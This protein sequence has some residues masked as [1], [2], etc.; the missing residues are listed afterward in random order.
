MRNQFKRQP[1][2]RNHFTLW[3]HYGKE[4]KRKVIIQVFVLVKTLILLHEKLKSSLTPKVRTPS[5]KDTEDS[6]F[7]SYSK[8]P[9]ALYLWSGKQPNSYHF[10][11]TVSNGFSSLACS[12]LTK[13]TFLNFRITHYIYNK[14]MYKTW[15]KVKKLI[16]RLIVI[17]LL[18][19]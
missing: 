12:A 14:I 15:F 8:H 16:T 5:K 7:N 13:K 19:S 17:Y 10:R 6:N 18:C 3:L 9:P 1:F 4:K 11:Q 2:Q